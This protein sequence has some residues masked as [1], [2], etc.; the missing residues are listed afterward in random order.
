MPELTLQR[1]PITVETDNRLRMLK[2]RLGIAPN[3]LCRIGL[4]LSLEEP[5][6]PSYFHEKLKIG[7]E[8]NRYTLLG[9][10]DQAF[11]SL[12]IARLATESSS[13]KKI[14]TMFIAHINRGVEIMASR[15][16]SVQ[17]IGCILVKLNN[18]P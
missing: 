1:I 6:Q 5:S 3:I 17:D 13:L 15:L 8:I 9:K 11:I 2:A 4:C 14:D 16:K 18:N 7:R 10:Y 12:L